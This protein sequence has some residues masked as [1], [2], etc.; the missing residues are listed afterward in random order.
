MWDNGESRDTHVKWVRETWDALQDVGAGEPYVNFLSDEGV[1]DV[2]AAYGEDTYRRL[3]E[4][5]HRYD[6]ANTFRLNQ[7]IRAS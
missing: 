7:N 1:D 5:K 3:V 6:P 4:L 2:R